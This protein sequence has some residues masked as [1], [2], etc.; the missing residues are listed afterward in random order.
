RIG[1]R[2]RY[3][4]SRSPTRLRDA[5]DLAGMDQLAETD[6]A[7]PEL[8]VHRLRAPAP[9]TPGVRPHLELGLA[10][11]LLDECLLGHALRNPLIPTEREAEGIEQRPA[12]GIVSGC[13]HDRDVHPA[14][15]VDR[16]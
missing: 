10:L 13:G 4:T 6:A 16:V 3:I 8:A 7:Q 5:G 12:L 15:H 11:L 2:H 14:R 1:H 9:P